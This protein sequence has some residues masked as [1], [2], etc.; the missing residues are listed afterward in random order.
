VVTPSGC[1]TV[2]VTAGGAA[3]PSLWGDAGLIAAAKRLLHVK[4]LL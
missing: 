4:S 3:Q 2:R 1:L